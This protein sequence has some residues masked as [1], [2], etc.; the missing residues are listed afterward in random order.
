MISTVQKNNLDMYKISSEIN[1]GHKH[2]ILQGFPVLLLFLHFQY[3][4]AVAVWSSISC[5][6][7]IKH[8]HNK[9]ILFAAFSFTTRLSDHA[10]QLLNDLGSGLIQNVKFRDT[11]GFIGQ[12]GISGFGEIE[13]VIYYHLS[14]NPIL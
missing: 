8:L 12:K 3:L 10:K 9:L 1:P 2:L 4:L 13:Q 5:N 6:F 7:I 11:W 14:E